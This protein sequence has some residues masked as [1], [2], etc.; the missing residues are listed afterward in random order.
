MQQEAEMLIRKSLEGNAASDRWAS[1]SVPDLTL[2]SPLWR[3]DFFPHTLL[4]FATYS[5]SLLDC[6]GAAP[7]GGHGPA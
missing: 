1:N 7:A 6:S 4:K 5:H 3:S 2:N